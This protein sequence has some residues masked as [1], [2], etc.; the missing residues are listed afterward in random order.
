MKVKVFESGD[1]PQGKFS[2]ERVKNI[3]SD[4]KDSIKGVF[5]HTS[6]WSEIN[7][8]PLEIASFKDFDIVEANN[9]ATVYANIDFN[10]KGQSYY[11][12]GSIKGISVEIDANDK[13][14]KIAVLPIGV[15][16]AIKGAEFQEDNAAIFEFEELIEEMTR[17]EVLKSLTKEEIEAIKLDGY[18]IEVKEFQEIKPK[19][20][21][22]IRDEIMKE[23][24]LKNE[25]KNKVTEFM[26]SN[27]KKITPGMRE[28][29]TDSNMQVIFANQS[30][31]FEAN[32]L[33]VSDFITNLFNNMPD[34]ITTDKTKVEF[35]KEV[36]K[37]SLDVMQEAEAR[38]KAKYNK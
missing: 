5:A 30:L 35:E 6:K 29:M 2:I 11:N 4:V 28:I 7:K 37:T 19:T 18:T 32:T 17:E 12:D 31:E 14:N 33:N 38:T 9:K 20:E 26:S 10:E 36:E 15:T 8:E 1:Y 27:S 34:L 25:V 23:F 13:L 22:E 24:E 3:F 16:P 21:Q